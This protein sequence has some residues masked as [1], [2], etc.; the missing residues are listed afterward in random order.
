MVDCRLPTIWVKEPDGVVAMSDPT[1]VLVCSYLEPELVERIRTA[2]PDV[3][4]VNEPELLAVPAYPCDHTGTPR[5]L[6]PAD[7]ARWDSLLETAEVC[8]DFDW[9]DPAQLLV[10]APALRWVQATSAGIGGYVERLGIADGPVAFTT[11][12]GVHAVPLAEFVLTGVL[13]FI[14]DV[15][16]LER[17]QEQRVWERYAAGSL[18]GRR[19]LV[20]G[21]G[22]IGRRVAEVL[23]ALGVEVWGAGRPG[24]AYDLAAASRI[25]STADL[26]ELL[27]HCS[28]V[29]LCTPLTPATERLIGAAELA[30]MPPGTLLVNIARGQVV[31]EP[32]MIEAL[33]E[34]RLGG[35]V[36]DVAST[37][38]LP[39]SSPLWA[40]DNVLISPH[41]ASTL[42][43]ENAS[44]VELFI[45]N[46]GRYRSG[47]PLRNLY[48]HADGY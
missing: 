34:R 35:A 8:F 17:M 30:T 38:P 3:D 47:A 16:H 4:V 19:A 27:P 40:M 20:I 13:H 25:G 26:D 41:S 6:G 24:H 23:A 31:D 42:V 36:L 15:P 10:R 32:A 18:A 12:A 1:R 21:L 28:I 33:H 11:A 43:T 9:R 22:S 44:I 2:A 37:E 14:K 45:D 46:L 48:H 5:E 7:L 29:V 39:E